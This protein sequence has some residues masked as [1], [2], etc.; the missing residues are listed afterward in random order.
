MPRNPEIDRLKGMSDQAF[1]AKQTAYD[2]MK[3]LGQH[4]SE[5]KDQMDASWEEVQ[6]ARSDMNSAYERQQQEWEAYRRERDDISAQINAVKQDADNAHEAMKDAFE[7]ASDAYEN[8]DKASAPFYSQEGKDYRYER[9]NYNAEKARLIGIAKSMTPPTSDFRYYK[10]QYNS[11]MNNQ[12]VLQAEYRV[13]KAQHEAA[14]DEFERAKERFEVARAAFDQAVAEE[15]AK[16]R[17][18]NCRGCGATIR[19]NVE[20]SHPPKYCKACKEKFQQEQK[21][22][23]AKEEKVARQAGLTRS[24]DV[25]VRFKPGRGKNDVFFNGYGEAAGPSHGH[26]VVDELGTVHFL[27]DEKGNVIK[28]DGVRL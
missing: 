15:R 5:L 28:D 26:A 2:R 11:L 10:D 25:K 4:R 7:R 22:R 8:G 12:K 21:A 16:W 23:M 19:I 17:D 6:S 27:R 18:E 3:P 13:I 1:T 24:D 9:D 20:W 14:R